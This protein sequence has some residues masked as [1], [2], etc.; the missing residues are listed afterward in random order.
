[1]DTRSTGNLQP[2]WTDLACKRSKEAEPQL[3]SDVG[4]C[5]RALRV[6]CSC[7]DSYAFFMRASIPF[8]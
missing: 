7:D 8:Q 2:F 4:I 6:C 1:M 3:L 5:F